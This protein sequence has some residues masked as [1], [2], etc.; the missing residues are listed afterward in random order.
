[1][2]FISRRSVQSSKSANIEQTRHQKPFSLNVSGSVAFQNVLRT[3]DD[4][5]KDL[6]TNGTC[7]G[8]KSLLD[9]LI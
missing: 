5:C 7:M 6:P 2:K 3:T 1:M 9:Y 8:K 4:T